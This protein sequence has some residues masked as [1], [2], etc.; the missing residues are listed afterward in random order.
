MKNSVAVLLLI[1][2]IT[3][4]QYIQQT[5]AVSIRSAGFLQA[6]SDVHNG[7]QEQVDKTDKKAVASAQEKAMQAAAHA[8]ES[9][10]KVQ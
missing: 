9:W 3:N 8:K 7:Q 5:Q 1:G 4:F 10:Q 6:D 2:A